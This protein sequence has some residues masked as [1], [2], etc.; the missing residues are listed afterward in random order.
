MRLVC[1]KE[2]AI[3]DDI[4]KR[5]TLITFIWEYI[6]EDALI[7][8]KEVIKIDHHKQLIK[9]QLIK[10]ETLLIN[11]FP[12]FYQINKINSKIYTFISDRIFLKYSS[13]GKDMMFL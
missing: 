10:E 11:L 12:L 4:N 9:Y 2:D 7:Y 3:E 13:S 8:Q 6:L 5:D 1:K